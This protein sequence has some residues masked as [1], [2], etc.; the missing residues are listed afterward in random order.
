MK[1]LIEDLRQVEG[2]KNVKKQSGPV[3]KI[4]LFSRELPN[5]EAEIIRGDLRKT[6]QQ[7]R[8]VLEDARK[9][10]GINTWEWIV[11]PQKK[12]AET[13]LG[14]GKLTDRKDK[15]HKPAYYRVNIEN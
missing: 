10:N 12:Y 15:G 8:N 3:L 14:K 4:N 2:V 6:G 9:D 7:L 5:S 13:S 11:K 1:Q